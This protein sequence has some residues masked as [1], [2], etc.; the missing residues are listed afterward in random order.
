MNINDNLIEK[1]LIYRKFDLI[2]QIL[3]HDESSYK[4]IRNNILQNIIND[5]DYKTILNLLKLL[6]DEGKRYILGNNEVNILYNIIGSKIEYIEEILKY[7]KYIEWKNQ[8]YILEIFL[9]KYY[10]KSYKKVKKIFN[11]L[12]KN[13]LELGSIILNA[14]LKGYNKYIIK[15]LYKKDNKIINI[16]KNNTIPI[17]ETYNNKKLFKFLL[18]HKA[19]YNFIEFDNNILLNCII[20]N[21][22]KKY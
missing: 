20:N 3:K 5:K 8:I 14:C 15:K 2:E 12:L 13:K 4:N 6:N 7:D 21:K 16:S 22:Q 1:Y 11:F 17:V 19:D 9:S 10:K 18:K